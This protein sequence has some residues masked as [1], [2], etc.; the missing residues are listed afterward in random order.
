[1]LMNTIMDFGLSETGKTDMVRYAESRRQAV[2]AA[3]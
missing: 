1:M 3:I 2:V